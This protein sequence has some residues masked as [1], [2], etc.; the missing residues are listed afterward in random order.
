MRCV[1]RGNEEVRRGEELRPALRRIP[2][3]ARAGGPVYDVINAK[4]ELVDRVQLPVNREIRGFGPGD[5][6][7]LVSRGPGGALLEPARVR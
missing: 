6:V 3:R 1:A 5:I 4:G 2:T 7:Y